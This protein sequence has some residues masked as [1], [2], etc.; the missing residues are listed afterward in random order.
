MGPPPHGAPSSRPLPSGRSTRRHTSRVAAAAALT[1]LLSV[2][3]RAR[4]FALT[5]SRGAVL[6]SEARRPSVARCAESPSGPDGPADGGS[7]PEPAPRAAAPPPRRGLRNE[8]LRE[9]GSF[10]NIGTFQ[11]RRP[12]AAIPFV[13][14]GIVADLG[15]SM[16]LLLSLNP[17]LARQLRA[18]GVY[19]VAPAG[20]NPLACG[21][22]P[23][24][25][26]RRYYGGEPYFCS[27]TYPGDWSEDPSVAFAR[28]Q[29]QD[30]MVYS[31]GRRTS[32][33]SRPL[34]LVAVGP[35]QG[36]GRGGLSVSLYA[37]STKARTLS[38]ALGTPENALADLMGR[39]AEQAPKLRGEGPI[40]EVVAAEQV[41]GD[42]TTYRLE[43]NVRYPGDQ[44]SNALTVWTTALFTPAGSG[45]N[46]LLLT[47][48]APLRA[49]DSVRRVV[50]EASRSLA[51]LPESPMTGSIISPQ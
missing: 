44:D 47:G 38:E 22:Q 30:S 27:F 34:P 46:I 24:A 3:P 17:Q 5:G 42:D 25:C 49:P 11:I 14:L 36:A 48:V 26:Q 13:L 40:S 19:A 43:S 31:S 7:S 18:D 9:P 6:G 45:G 15:G 20:G 32:S 33:G 51:K 35:S 50:R 41:V 23:S 16:R 4:T 1:V 37:R 8:D 10:A 12:L 2:P 28:Q 21:L 39:F 29:Q